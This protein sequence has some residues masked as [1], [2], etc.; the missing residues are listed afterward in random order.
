MS[1]FLA[2]RRD[3]A[4]KHEQLRSSIARSPALC[5]HSSAATP[6]T[7]RS[8]A[9]DNDADAKVLALSL[10]ELAAAC[11]DNSVASSDVLHVYG[12]RALDAH[13]AT[14]CLADIFLDEAESSNAGASHTLRPLAGVPVSIKDCID[15][16]GHDTTLGFSARAG[17]PAR[18]DAPLVRLLRDA[19]AL[20][21]AKSTLP[22][23][24][25]SFECS[26]DLFGATTN[27]Y[28]PAFSPGASTGGGAALLAYQGSMVEVGTDIGGS[29]RYPAAYCGVYA[30]KGTHGRLPS[31]GCV[32]CTPGLESIPTITAPLARTLDDLQ[33]FWRRV[34]EM[35]PWE[36]DQ[37]CA[38]IPWRAVDYIATGQKLRFGVLADDGVIPP[39]PAAARA[40]EEVTRALI[41]QGHEV[42][43]FTPPSPLEGLKVGYQLMFSDGAHS[44]LADKRLGEFVGPALLTVRF[45][46]RLPLWLKRLNATF[47][48]WFSRP[49]GR[50]EAWAA[51][52]EVFH[53]RTAY[54]ERAL[55]VERDAYRAAWFDAWRDAKLDLLLTVP[56]AL[57]AVPMDPKASDKATLVSA[58]YA[59]LYNVLDCV[60]GAMPVT[61]VDAAQDAHPPDYQSAPAYLGMNDVARGVHDLY[62]AKAM[63]GLP[64]GVQVIGGRYQEE[65]VLAG[66]KV[67]EHALWES[68]RGF[69]PRKF[70]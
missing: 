18:A 29:V 4:R 41:K 47:L 48:R 19:G 33:E 51:L 39:T 1:S 7:S 38:P 70:Q 67:V 53:P 57:P 59:F 9:A 44:V 55:V 13:E 40:L 22:T 28:N 54:E 2:H 5:A 16:A 24:C 3:S 36:Y 50:N 64:V 45:I 26:S 61:Y 58:G 10:S 69:V 68:G 35:R 27:P 37:T 23:A 60:A 49:W 14:N 46:L 20:L 8:D 31:T 66:M 32:S 63:H 34:F 56:H 52:L 15:V 25:L 42:V 11:A 17:H 6:T 43:K 30:V 65:H 21:Y 62:D 12:R